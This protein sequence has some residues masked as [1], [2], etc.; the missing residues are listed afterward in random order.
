[1][2][3]EEELFHLL[4]GLIPANMIDAQSALDRYS[5]AIYAYRSVVADRVGYESRLKET[6][7]LEEQQRIKAIES[8]LELLEKVKD[9]VGT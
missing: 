2:Q 8:W 5:A 1:M 9:A 3:P 4:R 7:V 6:L